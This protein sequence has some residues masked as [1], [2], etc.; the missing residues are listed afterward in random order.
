MPNS[1][2]FCIV[3][4][5]EV[6]I[7]AD[8]TYHTCGAQPNA[9]TGTSLAEAQNIRKMPIDQ[10][11]NSEYQKSQRIKKLQGISDNLCQMCYH[12]ESIGS[13]SKR[14][15]ENLKSSISDTE[16]DQSYKCSPHR[17]WFDYSENNQGLTNYLKP[18]SY[19]ISLG[20]ECNFA[21]RMC[22]P[23]FSSKIASNLKMQGQW[24]GPVRLN[25][26]D[27]QVTWDYFVNYLCD[28]PDLKWVHIIGGE[29]LLNRRFED[30][31]D[32]LLAANIT[33]IYLGFTTNGSIVDH[34]LLQKLQKFRHVDIGISIECMGYLNDQIRPGGSYSKI[35]SNIEEYSK[36]IEESHVYVTIRTVPS[37]LSVHTLDG[38]YQ[39]CADR[40]LDIF[41]NILVRPE[42]QQIRHLPPDVKERLL[43]QYSRWKFSEP[44]PGISDPRDPNR[45]KEHI[46][47]EINAV[48]QSLKLPN[49][50]AQTQILYQKLQEWQWLSDTN[51]KKYFETTFSYN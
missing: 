4:W 9:I 33:D 32:R 23:K 35:L 27:D 42:Y 51:I 21:C 11:I 24:Q 41:S 49:D 13:S 34:G 29:P 38:L 6:H 26:T 39:W 28:T 50:S 30:L 47:S 45:F 20:N 7:N 43:E 48:I 46:D 17:H 31:I 37:A 1:K 19:H 36:Y 22:S 12:E 15:K 40:K 8:G 44:L 14:V 25:W 5:F 3:P 2:I 18:T 10:W 16:F